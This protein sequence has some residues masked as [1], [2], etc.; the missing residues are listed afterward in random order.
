MARA[1]SSLPVPV[2][3]LIRTVESLLATWDTRDRTDMSAGEA[4]TISSNIEVLSISSRSAT[5]SCRS[6]SSALLRSLDIGRCDVPAH[7]LSPVVAK[8]VGAMH[9]PTI[10]SVRGPQAHLQLFGDASR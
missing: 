5:F 3:P 10:G 4:P 9:E 2:S 7:E 8:W 6:L 1:M